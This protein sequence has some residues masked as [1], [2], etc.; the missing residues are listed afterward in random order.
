MFQ[1]CHMK[2]S[3]QMD[4][5][6][7]IHMVFIMLYDICEFEDIKLSNNI[8]HSQ[9]YNSRHILKACINLNL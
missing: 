1:K 9:L 4:I 6:Q 5:I 2:R 8:C 7:D 3:Y